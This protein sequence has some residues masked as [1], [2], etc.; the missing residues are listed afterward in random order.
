MRLVRVAAFLAVAIVPIAARAQQS[1][2]P[3]ATPV[4]PGI[5][6]DYRAKGVGVSNYPIDAKGNDLGQNGWVEHRLRLGGFA[7]NGPL[8]MTL[9]ADLAN[10][11]LFGDTS[12]RFPFVAYRRDSSSISRPNVF[13]RNL[14]LEARTPVALIRAGHMGS[15][16]GLG[17]VANDGSGTP[18]WGD[19]YYGDEVERLLVATR[20]L[21]KAAPRL[22]PLVVALGGDL[23]YRDQIADLARGDRAFQGVLSTVWAPEGKQSRAGLYVVRRSQVDRDGY[24]LSVW[25]IDGH[26]RWVGEIGPLAFHLEG[27]VAR[28]TGTTDTVRDIYAGTRTIDQMGAAAELGFGFG[29]IDGAGAKHTLDLVLQ[30]GYASGD[31]RA[32]D[33]RLTAFKF[34]PEYNV[35]L[36]LFEE[37]LAYQSAATARSV[38]DPSTFGRPAAGA[39]FLPTD[40]AVTN[41]HYAM[42]TLRW[43]PTRLLTLRVG[44]LGAIADRSLDDPYQTEGL[45][46]GVRHTV[47]GST[48]ASRDLGN[49]IDAGVRYDFA[50]HTAPALTADV[51][52]GRFFPGN[53]FVDASGNRMKPVD[54]ILAGLTLHW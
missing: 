46:G 37:V 10:G 17:I 4:A 25:V 9:E 3:T 7:K 40:G 14:F 1:V 20:P 6:G 26:A 44:W 35:G 13:L 50:T 39:R 45:S 38:A 2:E 12:A 15:L 30:G 32:Y 47:L 31:D 43:S 36:V 51:Q 53:A 48:T 23:V 24:G 18:D 52:A 41:A 42:P 28:T 22:A 34:D 21:A 54:R 19:H 11:V 8:S 33:G 5:F 29:E 49:E 27:E 16:W